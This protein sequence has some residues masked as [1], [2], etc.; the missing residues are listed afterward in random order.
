MSQALG[1]K[2]IADLAAFITTF[3]R[4][5]WL[6]AIKSDVSEKAMPPVAS[7]GKLFKDRQGDD[8]DPVI[9][10]VRYLEP[11]LAAGRPGEVFMM[12]GVAAAPSTQ[13][14]YSF[15]AEVGATMS[16]LGNCIPRKDTVAASAS[17]IMERLDSDFAGA[18]TL[19]PRL[20]DTDLTTFNSEALA[21]T[22]VI[23][24]VPTYPL[25]SDGSGKLRH[26]RVPKGKT[27]KFDKAN[28]TFEI[29]PNTRFYK[30]FFKKVID[31]AGQERNR[32]M[33][34]RLIVSR[35]DTVKEDG[36]AKNNALFGTY[37]WSD[38]ET[39]ATLANLP[40]RDGTLFADQVLT[41]ITNEASYQEI[42]D[43]VGPGASGYASN[44]DAAFK[45]ALAKNPSLQRHYAIPGRIRCEQCHMGSST[46]DFILGFNPL[47]VARRVDHT[48]GTYEPTGEDEL[49]Q[50]QRLIDYGVISG[51]TSPADVVV[52]ENSQGTRKPR[53]PAELTAQ[54]YMI[55][56]CAHCHNP[57]G[58]PSVTKPELTAVLDFIPRPD[59]GGIFQFPLDLM[60]PVRF[61]GA[62]GDV[63]IP[64]ITPSLHDYPVTTAALLR[65]DNG[66]DAS[67]VANGASPVQLV[68]TWTP[69]FFSGGTCDSNEPDFIAIKELRGYCGDR[70]SGP[71]YIPAPW[72]SLI[73]R[74]VDA[75]FPYID[76]FVP[77]PHMPMNSPGFDCR[78]PRIMGE[79]MVGLPAIRKNPNARTTPEHAFSVPRSTHDDGSSENYAQPYAE[80]GPADTR[81][82]SALN[83]AKD[84][85]REYRGGVRYSYCEESLS[86][87]I[88][89]PVIP[90]GGSVYRPD[91]ER[92]LTESLGASVVDPRRN[93]R[94]LPRLGIP[95]HSHWFNYD[96]T[97]PPDPWVPR[98]PDWRAIVV[99]GKPDSSVPQGRPLNSQDTVSRK[100]LADA[101]VEASLT[102]ELETFSTTEFPF[103][104]WVNKPE[105]Q[106]KLARFRAQTAD[107]RKG[108]NLPAWM[109]KLSPD[110]V[111]F[112]DSPG[113][114]LFRQVCI[115]C[116]GPKADGKGLQAEAL[117]SASEGDARP[118]NFIAGLFGPPK[119][120]GSNYINTFGPD[121]IEGKQNAA[122]YMAWMTLGGTLKNIPQ[123][124][125][126]LVNSAQIF[127]QRRKDLSL[128][129]GNE[130]TTGNMLQI[131][132]GLCSTILPSPAE[133]SFFFQDHQEALGKSS[134]VEYYPPFNHERSP[135]IASTGDKQ[136]WIELCSRFSPAIVRVY[137]VT[138]AFIGLSQMFYAAGDKLQGHADFPQGADVLDHNQKIQTG[139][140]AAANFYPAC[141]KRSQTPEEAA[142]LELHPLRRDLRMPSCP[143]A[144]LANG[145]MMWQR[146]NP[147]DSQLDNVRRWILRGAISAG[148][149][150]FS[151]FDD[152]NRMPLK[153]QYNQCE[154]LK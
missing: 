50:L 36:S 95:Y 138:P 96:P 29:P 135:L 70:K 147:T 143:D 73:Y 115:N 68:S 6:A 35:P 48:G 103:A 7:G 122:R 102:K 5:V 28:Q 120:P 94:F 41:Y 86:P 123:D 145:T 78:A 42:V 93:D 106:G 26:I 45:K 130:K 77:F 124:I 126:N 104:A 109:E 110:E 119:N 51:M 82:E 149:A 129:G 64:Y 47:Q 33:E 31:R 87:D 97:D 91:P 76:D 92:Y 148:M 84:R 79:W 25:W 151:Y 57:R 4:A 62:N 11:W 131:A 136:L 98:R 133:H 71:S 114:Y 19:P 127:G 112:T 8:N 111:I 83:S 13:A 49:N 139:V 140:D 58:L 81:Y 66:E 72:R 32:K 75:P 89:D 40:Y 142:L 30:T 12:G 107:F 17:G 128:V 55:G 15:P 69:K 9:T 153:P 14:D 125:I 101:L 144:F 34:T 134:P 22:G 67:P 61:R 52:L 46:K 38:D 132:K 37:V 116:H 63:P 74:N 137:E 85:L 1:G 44:L 18:T 121:P 65:V 150:V 100:L 3:D 117:A 20:S 80:V 56:N 118:A 23:A 88:Y 59:G 90:D 108:S 43:S 141:V 10:L 27:V 53:T 105:C 154:L 60:S 24:F 99:E 21:G 54:G 146:R 39:S 16:N 113:A 152:P 2:R